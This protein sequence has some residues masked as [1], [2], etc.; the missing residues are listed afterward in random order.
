MFQGSREAARQV[1]RP[2]AC[3]LLFLVWAAAAAAGGTD[4]APDHPALLAPLTP[5]SVFPRF[6]PQELATAGYPDHKHVYAYPGYKPFRDA[7]GVTYGLFSLARRDSVFARE[8]LVVTQKDVSYRGVR[9]IAPPEF[10]GTWAIPL[11]ESLDWA[12]RELG[13]LLRHELS[14]T[15]VVLTTR[16][17][18]EYR[19]LTGCDVIRLY[20]DRGDVVI[21]QPVQILFSRTLATHAA[22]HMMAVRLIK[23]LAGGGPLPAWLVQGLAS[24]LAED[25]N[26]FLSYVAMFRGKRPVVIKPAAAEAVLASPPHED[27]ATDQYRFS[28]AGYSAFLMTW[29]LVEHRGGLDKVRDLLAAV[30]AGRTPDDACYEVYGL[31]LA[32]LTEAL[33]ATRRAEPVGEATQARAPHRPPASR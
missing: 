13:S 29:E 12:Q 26:H 9:I 22:F 30:G 1:V 5:Q 10:E 2:A 23:D 3:L 33:D 31:D 21:T 28:V 6:S 27:G 17:L 15:L 24:Y 20:L 32:A 14:D 18:Q 4:L 11:L 19:E 16:D 7:A 8:G 25:G